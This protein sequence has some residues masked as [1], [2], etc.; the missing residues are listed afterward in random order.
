[1]NFKINRKTFL[2]KL[3]SVLVGDAI[4]AFALVFLLKPN[5]MISG[6]IEGISII[7]E[8]ITGLNLGLL[9]LILNLPLL[10]LGI[11]LLD[12]EFTFF[13]AISI[14]VLS[15]YISFFE[16]LKPVDFALTNNIVL[17]ALY[18]GVIRG[19]GAGILFRNGTSAGGLDIVGAIMKKHYNIAIGNMLLI[20]NLFII[21]VSA[22]IFTI[23]RAL[24][25]LV[26]LFISYRVIDK[27]QMGVGQQKQVF[28]VSNKSEEIAHLIQEKVERG[29]TFLE[30][31][32]AYENKKFKILYVVCSPR[33]LVQIKNIVREV[34]K[35]SF[36]T[37]TDTSEI[38]GRGFRR[39][40]I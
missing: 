2:R 7:I 25:T 26:A 34:D 27:I 9:V 38:Q 24:F 20:L 3:S 28:I 31:E 12:K 18:G 30:G 23:D 36:L 17:A 21:G 29:V 5:Q 1:M 11:F 33:E 16:F 32:G 8:N 10:I 39:I 6:G 35:K 13:S 19:I 14:F 22:L 4:S 15:S 37:V 40:E